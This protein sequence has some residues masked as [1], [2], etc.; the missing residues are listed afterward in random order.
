VD[1]ALINKDKIRLYFTKKLARTNQVSFDLAFKTELKKFNTSL[2]AKP[3]L[4]AEFYDSKEL[5][6]ILQE[7]VLK[8]DLIKQILNIVWGSKALIY[9]EIVTAKKSKRSFITT[10]LSWFKFGS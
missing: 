1:K 8:N 7:E 4:L 10:L 2:N 9:E 6:G 3:D 5:F